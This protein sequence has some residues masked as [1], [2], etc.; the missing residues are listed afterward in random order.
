LRA[1]P[2]PEGGF[3]VLRMEAPH[4]LVLGTCT[5]MDS[6]KAYRPDVPVQPSHYL[7][8]TWAFHLQPQ[9]E[10][11]TRLIVRA[12]LDYSESGTWKGHFR[13]L[14]MERFHAFMERKQLENIKIRAENFGVAA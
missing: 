9:T 4:S 5:D 2:N 6:G 1:G 11:T 14:F 12:R 7:C 10:D 13:T 8:T 3:F